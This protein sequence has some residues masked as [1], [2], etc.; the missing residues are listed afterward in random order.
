MRDVRTR[1]L[2]VRFT[3]D[4]DPRNNG[5]QIRFTAVIHYPPDVKRRLAT[6]EVA[7]ARAVELAR[8]IIHRRCYRPPDLDTLACNVE[9][10]MFA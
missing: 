2:L 5:A 6:L 8:Q 9:V 1:V 7:K 4:L 3:S 10:T